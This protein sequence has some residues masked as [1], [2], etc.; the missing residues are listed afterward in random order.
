[1]GGMSESRGPAMIRLARL[2][3]RRRRAI[4]VGA[5]IAFV[6]SGALGGSVASKLS[7]GGFEDPGAE[8][9]RAQHY[10]DQKFAQ[11]GMPNILLLVTA[12]QG[13]TVDSPQAAAAGHAVTTELAQE[14]GVVFAASYW[15]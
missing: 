7:S 2:V 4:L 10:L 1:M 5:V 9:T 14:R 3:I 13:L 8:S 15:S 12:D 6:L 11:G